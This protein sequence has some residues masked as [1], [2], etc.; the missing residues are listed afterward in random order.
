MPTE[1]I[2]EL[3]INHNGSFDT[4]VHLA[5]TA[6]QN[7]A[8]MVKL[9][10][11]TPEL[12]VPKSQWDVPRKWFDG[13]D[14]TYIEYRNKME[15]SI[16]EIVK[17]DEIV[18]RKFGE[19]RWT[20]SVWDIGALDKLMR[21]FERVDMP[22]YVPIKIPSAKITD[23][24]LLH[25]VKDTKHRVIFSAGMSAILQ[26]QSAY[27]V[28]MNPFSDL[29]ILHCNSSYP[30]IDSEVDLTTIPYYVERFPNAHIGFSSHSTS[31][32]PA[33]YSIV[34][35]ARV[36]EFHYTLDRT[37]QG[38]DHAASL[39]APAVR[40]LNRERNRIPVVMGY[41][42]LSVWDSEKPARDKLR[43]RKDDE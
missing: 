43:G 29:T 40:L 7:G 2:A 36:V 4:L 31:P 16:K 34:L 26:V 27:E 33:I 42:K 23:M 12:C 9:Q 21:I 28:F 30:T 20:A 41:P 8:D 11:R 39:E 37:M 35:G 1:L 19:G 15:F 32:Y 14:M 25:A 5:V 17:F 3:G 6:L 38:S 10:L 18:S 24:E 22:Y 13:T